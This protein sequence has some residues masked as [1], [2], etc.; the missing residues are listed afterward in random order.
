MSHSARSHLAQCRIILC[1]QGRFSGV[2]RI[3]IAGRGLGQ[4]ASDRLSAP[5]RIS[6][7]SATEQK[8]YQKNNHYGR[9]IIT[10][11][12]FS[13]VQIESQCRMYARPEVETRS[14]RKC[15]VQ[16]LPSHRQEAPKALNSGR[17]GYVDRS[18]TENSAATMS[19]RRLRASP[20]KNGEST[21][22]SLSTVG[23]GLVR[24]LLGSLRGKQSCPV[25]GT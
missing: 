23:K 1:D 16:I 5:T 22:W 3:R 18:P 8:Q 14:S 2:T 11:F 15:Y 21:I 7:A 24:R 13:A 25:S 17:V 19:R 12:G 4:I 20:P 10:S 9:H 6:P